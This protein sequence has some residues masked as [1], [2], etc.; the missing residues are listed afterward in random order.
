MLEEETS[1]FTLRRRTSLFLSHT[2][3]H[4]I[5]CTPMQ[6]HT[7]VLAYCGHSNTHSHISLVIQ[8]PALLRCSLSCADINETPCTYTVFMHLL[9]ACISH[10]DTNMS[11][12]NIHSP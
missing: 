2:H 3:I 10:M 11:L 9:N 4:S 1:S 7:H 6:A 5:V 12:E 8:C